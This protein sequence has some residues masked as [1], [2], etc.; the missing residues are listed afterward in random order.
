MSALKEAIKENIQM[1]DGMIADSKK[2]PMQLAQLRVMKWH[3]QQTLAAIN[4]LEKLG[5]MA[6]SIAKTKTR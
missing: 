4:H 2:M 3:M 5:T 1:I 6:K